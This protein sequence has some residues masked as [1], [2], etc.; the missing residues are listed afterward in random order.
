MGNF[1][2][3]QMPDVQAFAIAAL[4]VD[5]QKRYTQA[6]EII[7]HKDVAAT[8]C[9]GKFYPFDA[10]CSAVKSPEIA[11]TTL[12]TAINTL[13]DAGQMTSGDYWLKTAKAGSV[14]CLDA[15]II[16]FAD[17]VKKHP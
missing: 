5:I 2:T 9:P 12:E 11:K 17:Y 4:I 7:R 13:Q 16:K 14:N 1:E 8:A 6:S 10:I 15:L 3:E